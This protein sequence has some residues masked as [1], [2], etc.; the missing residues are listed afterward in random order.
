MSRRRIAES[1]MLITGAS[2]GIGRALALAAAARGA[3]VLAVA[4]SDHLLR[5]LAEQVRAQGGTL[6]T[7]VADITDPNDRQRMVEAALHG[8]GGLD[9]LV[10]NAGI[11]ATGHFVEV[12]PERLRKIMEVNFF[13]V[14][15]TVR[16]FLPLL[17]AGHRPAIVNIS[18]IAGK[19]GIPARSEYSASKFALQ[20]FSEALRAELAKDGI[21]VLVV[22][23]GLTDTNFSKNMLEQ[24]ARMP[25]DHMR[26][27]K[28]EKAAV[29]T[30]RA[31]ERGRHEVCLTFQGKLLVFVSRFLPR[32]ADRIAARRVRQLFRDELPVKCGENASPT[33][34]EKSSLSA[35]EPGHRGGGES[36]AHHP[37]SR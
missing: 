20:G 8:F 16:S 3:K 4:R 13:G 24:K 27:M 30:L 25:V 28:P 7:V 22:C 17:R 32:L 34:A 15:E 37:F 14:T 36:L 31:I 35:G 26:G 33:R 21:D 11:G 12:S 29:A 9:V 23:P 19:R 18:S 2:Q 10:N 1:R 6:E 5:A